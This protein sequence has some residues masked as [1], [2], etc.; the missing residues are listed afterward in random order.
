MTSR[1]EHQ[2]IALMI[3][4]YV[5]LTLAFSLGPIFEG[6]DEIEDYRFIRTLVQTGS[7][8]DAR[9]QYRGEYHQPPLYYVLAAPLAWLFKDDGDFAK[10]DGR[11][12]PYYGDHIGIPGN[13]NKNLYLHTR[14]EVFPYTGNSTARAVH[15]IRLLSIAFGT[16]TIIA[17]YAVFRLLWPDRP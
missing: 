11:L 12:N 9:A 13:D 15:V 14:D 16:D 4:G 7:L 17:S 3:V 2:I 10:I 8:P 5:F 1:R 6:P